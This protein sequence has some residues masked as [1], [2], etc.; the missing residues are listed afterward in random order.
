MTKKLN[1]WS[2]APLVEFNRIKTDTSYM[3]NDF[4]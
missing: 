1:L 4:T 3:N 2:V